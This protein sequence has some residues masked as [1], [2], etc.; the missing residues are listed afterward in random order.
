MATETWNHEQWV[1]GRKPESVD[2]DIAAATVVAARTPMGQLADTGEFVAW[3]PVA[4]DGS[5]VA[6]RIAGFDIDTTSGAAKK[7]LIASGT[8]NPELIVWPAGVTAAQ[9]ARAFVGTAI[10]LQAPRG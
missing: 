5:Q 9:K 10:S 3:D 8:F 6:V 7:A 1:T 4:A 2:S